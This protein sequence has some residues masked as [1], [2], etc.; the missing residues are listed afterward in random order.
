MCF[1]PRPVE[2]W[3]EI[4]FAR[5]GALADVKFQSAPRRDLGRNLEFT[6]Q[7]N[8]KWCFNPRPVETWGEIYAHRI[9]FI[10]P[11]SFNPRPVE[12]WGEITQ[13]KIQHKQA[14]VS[15]RAPSRLGAKLYV[16]K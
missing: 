5:N 15:I 3:G 14:G 16:T 1:N 11:A 2:T 10:C 8:G 13:L 7:K 4:C 12:T 9:C 6:V